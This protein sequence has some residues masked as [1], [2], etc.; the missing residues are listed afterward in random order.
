MPHDRVE[1]GTEY[2]V[3]TDRGDRLGDR[4]LALERVDRPPR[5]D[6][7]LRV[8]VRKAATQ[9]FVQGGAP[10]TDSMSKATSTASTPA[11]DT[12]ATTSSSG[13]PTHSLPQYWPSAST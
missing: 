13:L 2:A 4:M 6:E 5:A 9:E 7:R 11:A 3:L 1:V 10:V 8:P 12:S